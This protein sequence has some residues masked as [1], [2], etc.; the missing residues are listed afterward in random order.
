M[1]LESKLYEF[2]SLSSFRPGQKEAIT[3]LLEHEHTLA[4][5]PTGTGKSLVY[6]LPGKLLKG[7]VII[8]SP[9]LSLMQD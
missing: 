8:I 4:M 1:N 3:A 2:F 7:T 5:L 6:Q 9:L